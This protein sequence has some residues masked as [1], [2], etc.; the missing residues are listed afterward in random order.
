M[1][2]RFLSPVK[3]R[4][5]REEISAVRQTIL[6]RLLYLFSIV[7]LPAASIGAYQT[8]LQGRW[9]FSVLYL[10]LYLI[11]L[12]AAFGARLFSYETRAVVLVSCLYLIALGVLI[13]IGLSGVGVL[14][15]M[16]VCFLCAVLFGLRWGI[17]AICLCIAS[18][19]VVGAGM[20]TGFIRIYPD[21]MMTSI[22]P[23]AWIT[24]L[25]VF[26]MITCVTV[27]APEMFRKRIERSVDV[28]EEQKARLE[29]NNRRLLK[30]IEERRKVEVA[31]RGSEERYRSLVETTSDWIWE[32]DSEGRYTYTS[33]RVFD[34]LGYRPEEVVGQTFFDLMPQEE[35][36][37]LSAPWE[38][39]RKKRQPFF[40]LENVNLHKDGRRIV[41][42][43]SAI[44]RVD[45]SG[46]LL[47]YRGIDRDITERKEAEEERKQLSNYLDNIINSMPSMLVGVDGEGRVS[48]WNSAAE[49]MTGVRAE[50]IKGKILHQILP[51]MGPEL[52][53]VQEAI[54]HKMVKSEVKIRRQSG[55]MVRYEDITVY[56]L[57]SD[58]AEG[59]VIRMDDVTERVRME[60][61][62]IQSEKMLS[63]G[64]LAAGMAHEINNPLGVILQASQNVLRRVSPDFPANYRTAEE[65]GTTLE[66]LRAYLERREITQFVEDI[67]KG[68][69]R[70]AAIV[71]NMLNF[72]RKPDGRGSSTH[73]EELLEQTLDLAGSDY[74]L[75]KKYDFR[76]IEIVRAY[77]SD[78]P[79]VVCQAS[80]IQQVFLNILRNGAEAMQERKATSPAHGEDVDQSKFTLRLMHEGDMVRVEIEDS[81]PG[82]DEATRKRV[83]EPFFT[84]KAPDIGT[85]LGLS[86]SYFIVVEEHHGTLRVESSPGKGARFIIQLP[87]A[88]GDDAK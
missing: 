23:M 54:Q 51:E 82:M 80:K 38:E 6:Y 14:I 13:R 35:V 86:V 31:L 50:Q 76:Q 65:C 25:C 2:K 37:R 24:F 77:D 30:E 27:I 87:V 46:R 52:D 40:G 79:M 5:E 20:V 57:V 64:G 63:V 4:P 43:S 18:M 61:M 42:E 74:D 81:G 7:G 10:G 88:G 26:F 58:G 9:V 11:F 32:V 75:K 1:F 67:R 70:A 17:A 78:V 44:P 71:S 49:K 73:L 48:Q 62:M 22:S 66:A 45:E 28:I 47:G 33:P 55:D 19:G 39:I 84:T 41:L 29:I 72:S 60:E 53:K 16:G 8:F 56:P 85:G 36:L 21:H 83:F 34:L 59:A 69:E 12:M 68:G 15:L 3:S